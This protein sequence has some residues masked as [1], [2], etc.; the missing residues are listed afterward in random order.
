MYH[1]ITN[2]FKDLLGIKYPQ[3]K[4]LTGLTLPGLLRLSTADGISPDFTHNSN[5]RKTQPGLLR[6]PDLIPDLDCGK[7]SPRLLWEPGS[8]L[9]PDCW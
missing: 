1:L 7:A 3:P 5:C 4:F 2:R 6:E 8:V 9:E